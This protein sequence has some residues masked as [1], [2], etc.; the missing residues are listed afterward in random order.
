MRPDLMSFFKPDVPELHSPRV[1]NLTNL[2][3]IFVTLQEGKH[4]TRILDRRGFK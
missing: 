4:F 2:Y 3:H 1:L